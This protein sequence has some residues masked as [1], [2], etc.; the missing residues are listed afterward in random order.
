MVLKKDEAGLL[1]RLSSIKHII[2]NTHIVSVVKG[3][4]AD[5]TSWQL[6]K[7]KEFQQEEII[8]LK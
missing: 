1:R 8:K 3:D 7:R 4:T 2:G 6:N 5:T